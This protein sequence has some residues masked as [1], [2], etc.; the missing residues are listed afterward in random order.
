MKISTIFKKINKIYVV[1]IIFWIL[2]WQIVSMVIG[3]EILLVSPFT[4]FM[5]LIELTRDVDFWKSIFVSISK[6]GLGFLLS[7]ISGILLAFL[8]SMFKWIK[9]ILEPIMMVFQ[10]V[11]V[12]SFI[13]LC[14]IWVSS[15]NLSMLISY[16]MVL[17][18]IYRNILEGI[19][20][21]PNDLVDMTRLFNISRFRRIRYIYL[22]EVASYLRAAC[23]ISLGM[24]WKAGVAAEVIG[25]PRHTIGE[26]LYTAKIYL[27]TEDLFAWTI[28]IILVSILFKKIFMFM[29]SKILDR[30]EVR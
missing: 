6:I 12:V 17:P 18:I 2:V 10:T 28:V 11:P 27:N 9:I 1:A 14:L 4:A 3:Q 13:I 26:N 7:F 15:A 29:I 21:I 19:E 30:L 16:I 22:S 8:A 25:M 5:R 23:K 24:C 20:S